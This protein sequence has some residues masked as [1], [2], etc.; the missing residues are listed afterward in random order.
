M[1]EQ[2]EVVES[3][4]D[5]RKPVNTVGRKRV[6][7]KKQVV[8][9]HGYLPQYEAARIQKMFKEYNLAIF[10]KIDGTWEM[11]EEYEKKIGRFL[12]ECIQL[13]FDRVVEEL[14][15]KFGK[16]IFKKLE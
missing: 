15:A 12:G 1:S 2:E 13:G 8:K 14:E 6:N 11:N 16:D 7:P 5:T 10:D 4:K 3:P 9:I